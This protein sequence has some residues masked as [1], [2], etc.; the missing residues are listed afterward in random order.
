MIFDLI[1]NGADPSSVITL[2]VL[3]FVCGFSIATFIH[4]IG[5]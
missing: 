3:A 1:N 2:T 5:R 4:R